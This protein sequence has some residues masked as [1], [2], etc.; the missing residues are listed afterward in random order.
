MGI[1]LLGPVAV[2]GNGALGP[3]DRVVLAVLALRPGEAVGA[4]RLAE[5]LWGDAPP[6][7]WNKVVPGCVMRLRRALGTEAI[8]TTPHGYRLT[9]PADE[10]DAHRFERLV[11]RG[12]ELLAGGEPDRAGH[13][14]A[15]A[16]ALWQGRALAEL[17]G[18]EPGRA[19]AARLEGLR[20]DA[21]EQRW[22]AE[23]AAGRH[24]EVFSDVSAGVAAAPLRERRW[25][26][27]ALAEYR[28]GRQG[29]ALRTIHRARATLV[30]QLGLNP[31]RELAAL[32]RAILV[33][34]PALQGVTAGPQLSAECPYLGLVPYDVGDAEVFFGR[35]REVAECV[36]R[37]TAANLLTIAG[38]SG[39]GKSSLVRAGV[40]AAL[41]RTG[42]VVT[43]ITP[44]SHPMSS[45]ADVEQD[46]VLVVDQCEE[47]TVLC[48]DPFER[49]AFFD[50]VAAHA[51]H[52][53]VIVAIRSDRLGDL[54][55]HAGFARLVEVSL[56]LLGAMG[57]DDLRAAIEGPAGSA[58]LLLEP[59]LVHVLVHDV[60]GEP[61]ALPLLSHALS[62]T[63]ERREG[64]TLTVEGYRQTGGIHGA[65]ARSAEALY[66]ALPPE[67]RG[68]LRTLLLR[69]VAV[70]ADGEPVRTRMPRR[71][72]AIDAD[73]EQ[74]VERLVAARLVTADE[75]TVELAHESLARAWPR[76]RGWLDDDVNGQRILR[77]LVGAADAWDTVGRPPSE[78]YRGIRLTQA[79]DWR[80]Q[81]TPDLGPVEHA[82][83]DAAQ[84]HEADE[85]RAVRRAARA[86]RRKRIVYPAV[87]AVVVAAVAITAILAIRRADQADQARARTVAEARGAGAL[88]VDTT[89]P[90]LATLLAVEGVRL[91]A[92]ADTRRD[93][94]TVLRRSGA[95]VRSETVDFEPDRV[96]VDPA[97]GT[98]ILTGWRYDPEEEKVVSVRRPDTLAEIRTHTQRPGE[99]GWS[100]VAGYRPDGTQLAVTYWRWH[101]TSPDIVKLLDPADLEPHAVQ[102]G[103]IPPSS[104]AYVAYSADGRYLAAS[105]QPDIGGGPN[106]VVVW[107]LSAPEV[108]IFQ[109]D[110]AGQF[111]PGVALSADGR[112]LY[113][114]E[115]NEVGGGA[116]TA[117]SVAGGEASAQTGTAGAP[118]GSC[119]PA[120]PGD[121]AVSPDGTTIAL[122]QRD[123]VALYDADTLIAE[124]P[125]TLRESGPRRAWEVEF[126]H[127]G[128]L[129]AADGD[130]GVVVVWDVTTGEERLA[131]TGDH[132][133]FSRDGTTLYTTTEHGLA[134]WDL[135]G[136]GRFV[137]VINEPGGEYFTGRARPPGSSGAPDTPAP[138]GSAVVYQH[139][140]GGEPSRILDTARHELLEAEPLE[141]SASA[142]AWRPPDFDTVAL[143]GPRS[144]DSGVRVVDRHTGDVVA[145][146]RGTGRS[147]GAMAFTAD[148]DRLLVGEITGSLVVLAGDSLE[149][150]G[151]PIDLGR[152]IFGVYPGADGRRAAVL[153]GG[154]GGPAERQDYAV[155]DLNDRVVVD[156]ESL[157]FNHAAGAISPAGTRLAVAGRDGEVG[158]RRLDFPGWVRPPVE[159]ALE[160]Q[161]TTVSY[162]G[163]GSAFVI[164]DTSGRVQL[165]DATTGTPIARLRPGQPGVTAS[166]VFH[167]DGHTVIIATADGAVYHWDTRVERTIE[168]A[169]AAAGRNMTQTEWRQAFPDRPYRETCPAS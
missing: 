120:A 96:V 168:T 94:H 153:M 138:D 69:L 101:P 39:C 141:G 57:D 119:C 156:Q 137:D 88:A 108:P 1:T 21:E 123:G 109:L 14:L 26:Q 92:N 50:A 150:I 160:G 18:W 91:D 13:V 111:A 110:A 66:E 80:T 140:A 31:G 117:Y 52:Q 127:D 24:E 2:D 84:Q 154:T 113:V 77:H 74:L 72:V 124:Q 103:G 144:P 55:E 8:E 114:W 149:P 41:Q 165:W 49:A 68:L 53:P 23:L 30:T 85:R 32:E 63:W 42:W 12:R 40:A 104:N 86:R 98:V 142:V 19:E 64:R 67:Q 51:A 122:A 158:I 6:P 61:G 147:P 3:R 65:V 35:D 76:L 130:D 79:L 34:D 83:L 145:E 36:R 78:L 54:T 125:S 128:E 16:L 33:H 22:A 48:P 4:D 143:T 116:L 157:G 102:L 135:A 47:A 159:A 132:P 73:H 136:D 148:G 25:A 99:G 15:E 45:L 151:A 90:A 44:G 17:R 107:D 155:V 89:D 167:P 28:S 133:A 134:E 131:V 95:L 10:V 29:D 82:F 27:L 118:V 37:I 20:L 164:A 166:A 38:P 161:V 60:K 87:A 115:T 97:T 93:L 7:S 121:L 100:D 56:Y 58:G 81:A 43:V 70:T 9:V 71:L 46:G 126:S 105:F 139:L 11:G 129:L 106:S 152:P 59:G 75:T 5:A 112:R 162:A 146:R 62:Q 169:C 163:D